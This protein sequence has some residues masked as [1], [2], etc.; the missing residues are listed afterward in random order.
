MKKPNAY[1]QRQEQ[2]YQ[3]FLDVGEQFGMQKMWDYIQIVLHDPNVMGK[4]TFGAGRLNKV[5]EALK[6]MANEYHTAFTYD[7]EAD[8]Y[9]EKLDA[10][11]RAIG[12]DEVLPFYERYPEL[13]RFNYDKPRKG[14]N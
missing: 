11:L 9:Q 12:G 6:A 5:Y 13:K 8:Y 1:L 2:Q 3:K 14:W 10:Q 7:K 4:D